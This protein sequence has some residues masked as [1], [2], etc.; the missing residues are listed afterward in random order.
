MIKLQYYNIKTILN[1]DSL[2]IYINR[3]WNDIFSQISS[4]TSPKHLFIMCKVIFK[5]SS[6]G[7]RT[8][9]HLVKTN[10]DDKDLFIMIDQI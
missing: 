10:Y 6:L 4:S 8:L 5:D 9:G 2:S 7:Y 3:F 1:N